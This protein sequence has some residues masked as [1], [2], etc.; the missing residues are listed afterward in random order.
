MKKTCA[1]CEHS[2]PFT[3]DGWA[4]CYLLSGDTDYRSPHEDKRR[5]WTDEATGLNV[6]RE[7]KCSEYE[8]KAPPR[9]RDMSRKELLTLPTRPVSASELPVNPDVSDVDL[10]SFID[11][12]GQWWRTDLDMNT[13][14]R[15]LK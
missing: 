9:P 1:T 3:S 15:R 6:Q 11:D 5:A 2:G 14:V 10:I 7:F 4:K 13:W 8:H 12:N